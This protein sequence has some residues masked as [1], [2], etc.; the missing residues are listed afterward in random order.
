M[1]EAALQKAYVIPL[2]PLAAWAIIALISK[3]LKNGSFVLSIVA[4]LTSLALS[5]GVLM[6]R[7]ADMESPAWAKSWYLLTAGDI[8]YRI[9]IQVDNLTAMML[10]IVTIVGA[11]VQVYSLGYMKGDE[12]IPRYFGF[13]SL[14][15]AA[16]L[17]LVMADNWIL[18]FVCWEL[19]GATSYL[20]I[21]FW[22]RKPSAAKAG[23]K[24]FLTTRTGDIGFLFGWLLMFA[25]TGGSIQLIDARNAV[26]R[27]PNTAMFAVAALLILWG[28]IGKSAQF[29][30]HIW[31][32]DAMEGPTPVS[33]LI[34]AATMVAAGVYLVARTYF[35][36][37][38]APAALTTVAY[39]GAFTAFLAATIGMAMND[40][41]R[42][43]AY[44]TV[45]QLGYMMAGLGA[46]GY[47]AGVFHLWTHAFFKALLF[48]ASGSVIHAMGTNDMRRMGKLAKYMPITYWTFMMGTLA[49][50]GFPGFSGFFSKDEI[51]AAAYKMATEHGHWLVF[52]FLLAGVF[53]TAFYMFRAIILTFLGNARWESKHTTET[54]HAHEDQGG[55]HD[56]QGEHGP[57]RHPHESPF[58]MTLPLIILAVFTIAAGF[59]ILG[60]FQEFV[61]MPFVRFEPEGFNYAVMAM[62]LSM[63]FFGILLAYL[64]YYTHAL[65]MYLL[66]KRAPILAL[67]ISRKYFFDELYDYFIVR[68]GMQFANYCRLFDK[69]II[70]GFVN[71]VG[72]LAVGLAFFSAAFDRYI[73]DGVVNG[74]GW[75]AGT[76]GQGVR[77]LQTGNVSNYFLVIAGSVTIILLLM[78]FWLR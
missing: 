20:L 52:I 41:K 45:S 14:F 54:A 32:P 38:A 23:K 56:A 26:L 6:A 68:P 48:L 5:V 16:M 9:G 64:V 67:A 21:G 34:H 71:A 7:L 18:L 11:C 27:D 17:G 66:R 40:I 3:Q 46:G 61:S 39:V 62:S 50:I 75:A 10:V 42:V 57:R 58:P 8:I 49:L 44:S 70:D 24:A 53:F 37:E 76:A 65:D 36:F 60:R 35:I 69:W 29:P 4:V 63:V 1:V 30:L 78:Q 33:A 73:V 25:L 19:V 47:A 74:F 72:Y 31:L 43:L 77:R 15:T 2:L 51:L 12:G 28:A 13:L 59:P 55:G 22:F